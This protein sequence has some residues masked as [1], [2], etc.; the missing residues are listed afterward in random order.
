M[1]ENPPVNPVPPGT[2]SAQNG[3]GPPVN[4]VAPASVAPAANGAS[5]GASASFTISSP[6]GNGSS[7]PATPSLSDLLGPKPVFSQRAMEAVEL[8]HKNFARSVFSFSLFALLLTY[9]FFWSQ[10]NPD[11][12]ML[13]DYTGPSVAIRFES[14]NKELREK[15]TD[16]N[17][18]RFRLARLKLDEINGSIDAWNFHYPV[19]VSESSSA[20]EKKNA[21]ERLMELDKNLRILFPAV[22]KLL[23]VPLGIDTYSRE[24]ITPEEREK[25]YEQLLIEKLNREKQAL[26]QDSKP[27]LVEARLIENVGS[28]VQNK[29]LLGLIRKMDLKGMD[30][31][32]FSEFLAQIRSADADEFSVVNTLRT[33]RLDWRQVIQDIHEV[34]TENDQHYGQGVF[35]ITGGFLFS[36]YR[37]D[38]K[39][40]RISLTGIT[41]T[42]DSKTFTLIANL[43]DSIEKSPKFKDIDFRSFSKS[44]DESGDFTSSLNIEFS[45]QA[46]GEKDPRDAVTEINS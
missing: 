15:Q 37:F 19:V 38:S 13:S 35:K 6:V 9:G 3:A 32:A 43:V 21:K 7:S 45:L 1:P 36:S 34:V 22:Q 16:A 24:P 10:L 23:N 42:I 39:S 2:Q 28:L 46:P 25:A 31:K 20:E 8:K 14:G 5:N 12:T 26:M 44:K 29:K 33:K 4:G 17:H 41:K 18:L 11:F 27:N 40:G 30:E